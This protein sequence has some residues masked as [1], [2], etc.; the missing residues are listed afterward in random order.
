MNFKSSVNCKTIAP[1]N[2]PKTIATLH[3]RLNLAKYFGWSILG[4]S[5]ILAMRFGK[6]N[7]KINPSNNLSIK[8]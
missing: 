3:D 1:N 5:E 7:P 6:K 2:N 4:A 8:K